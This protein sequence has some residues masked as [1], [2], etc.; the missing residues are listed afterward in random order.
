MPGASAADPALPDAAQPLDLPRGSNAAAFAYHRSVAPMLWMFVAIAG[1]ETVV[2]HGLVALRW[3]AVAAGLTMV[4]LPA[5]VWLVLA[6]RAMRRLPVLLEP[7]RLLMRAGGIKAVTLP[8]TDVAPVRATDGLP[9]ARRRAT[10]NLAL[11]AHPNVLV[12]LRYPRPG[13]RGWQAVAHR[14]DDPAAFVA[15]F[16]ALG[17]AA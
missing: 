9:R 5:L 12:E 8:L 1:T 7:D 4:T 2:V 14:L 6:I 16:A 3:P 15:A 13:R 11:L 10:L 17:A